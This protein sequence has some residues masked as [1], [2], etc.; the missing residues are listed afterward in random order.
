MM[1]EVHKNLPSTVERA[2][3]F[4]SGGK[5]AMLKAIALS[6]ARKA[7]AKVPKKRK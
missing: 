1:K 7:G 2:K 6:K 4:G 5:E 3:H